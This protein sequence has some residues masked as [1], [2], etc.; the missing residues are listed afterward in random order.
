MFYKNTL[1]KILRHFC[2]KVITT[3]SFTI[4]IKMVLLNWI[5]CLSKILSQNWNEKPDVALSYSSHQAGFK[6]K[7]TS[8]LRH[9]KESNPSTSMDTFFFKNKLMKINERTIDARAENTLHRFKTSYYW[10]FGQ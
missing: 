2:L 8:N 6:C 4:D 9:E 10:G 3:K 7:V 1:M 5:T